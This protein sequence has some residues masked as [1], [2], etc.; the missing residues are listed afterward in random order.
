MLTPFFSV[1]GYL[2]GLYWGRANPA[3][4]EMVEWLYLMIFLPMEP[5][6]FRLF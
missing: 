3:L 1:I 4:G 6:S 2:F 5:N